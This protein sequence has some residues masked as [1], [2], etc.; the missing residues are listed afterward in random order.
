MNTE[1]KTEAKKD[2]D[3]EGFFQTNEQFIINL[4]ATDKRKNQLLSDHN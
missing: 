4:V 3:F 1:L 2:F